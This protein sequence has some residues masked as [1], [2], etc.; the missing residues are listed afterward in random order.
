VVEYLNM[1]LLQINFT[2]EKIL[3]I[4]VTFGEVMGKSLVSFL[5]DSVV[6]F[7]PE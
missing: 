7:I 3:R 4:G 2:T 6:G 1:H 5:I